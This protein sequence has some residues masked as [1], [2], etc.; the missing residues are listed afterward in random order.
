MRD[1]AC[2]SVNMCLCTYARVRWN[3]WLCMSRMGNSY[4]HL[5]VGYLYKMNGPISSNTFFKDSNIFDVILTKSH[6]YR[7]FSCFFCNLSAFTCLCAV[8]VFYSI[9]HT[10]VTWN[11]PDKMIYLPL[12]G[13]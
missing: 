11:K 4:K 3:I 8:T 9:L 5:N 7:K 1:W 12:S 2:T 13:A 6:W 10:K